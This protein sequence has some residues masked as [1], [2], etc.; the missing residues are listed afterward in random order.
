MTDTE[1]DTIKSYILDSGYKDWSI[2][3]DD[4]YAADEFDFTSEIPKE[5]IG[6]KVIVAGHY[7]QGK[8]VSVSF[9]STHVEPG[10]R[11][12][13]TQMTAQQGDEG[14]V[15]RNERE[16]PSKGWLCVAWRDGM[17]TSVT[18]G[19]A[20]IRDVMPDRLQ[21][22]RDI[23]AKRRAY[24]SKTK[25]CPT[26]EGD[27]FLYGETEEGRPKMEDCPTCRKLGRVPV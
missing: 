5:V 27:G 4:T 8:I 21:E 16:G 22:L 25:D 18:G 12:I 9:Q 7:A 19:S 10:D 3:H 1:I 17:T 24:V 15:F 2:C 26:C 6:I 20:P 14:V 23:S 13:E 11:V